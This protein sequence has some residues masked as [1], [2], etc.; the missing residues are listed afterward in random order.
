MGILD[1]L[2]KF[3]TVYPSSE[4]QVLCPFTHVTVLLP[5][6]MWII[7]LLFALLNISVI[8]FLPKVKMVDDWL[9]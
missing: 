6:V 7:M 4:V 3:K 5:V 8:V 9:E 1:S 2:T